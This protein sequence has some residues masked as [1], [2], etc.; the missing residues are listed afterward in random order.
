MKTRALGANSSFPLHDGT[1][2]FL[3]EMASLRVTRFRIRIVEAQKEQ[4]VC[5]PFPFISSQEIQ[6]CRSP[7]VEIRVPLLP[8]RPNQIGKA[9]DD[10]AA[11]VVARLYRV[12]RHAILVASEVLAASK[13]GV[14]EQPR[15]NGGRRRPAREH[16]R[17][18]GRDRRHLQVRLP[19][20]VDGRERPQGLLRRHGAAVGGGPVGRQSQRR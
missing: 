12:P 10:R 18:V 15:R 17:R 16:R 8:L 6:N 9:P 2:I 5:F 14:L 13:G 3:E 19:L 4:K 20:P 7:A 1:K 11:P